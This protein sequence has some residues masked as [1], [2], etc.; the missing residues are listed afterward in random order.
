LLRIIGA[1]DLEPVPQV[2]V[3]VVIREQVGHC[4]R[5]SVGEDG[6]PDGENTAIIV[7]LTYLV[8]PLA[9]GICGESRRGVEYVQVLVEGVAVLGWVGVGVVGFVASAVPGV[10]FVRHLENGQLAIRSYKEVDHEWNER[11]FH[12]GGVAVVGG[13][14]VPSHGQ[15][16]L[17]AGVPVEVA[18]RCDEASVADVVGAVDGGVGGQALDERA[19]VFVPPGVVDR[20][21][22]IVIPVAVEV[23]VDEVALEELVV[24]LGQ[25]FVELEGEAYRVRVGIAV[26][27]GGPIDEIGLRE[28]FGLDQGECGEQQD[29]QERVGV[30]AHL[31][32]G[33]NSNIE[34]R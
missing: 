34:N 19:V 32:S 27:V 2:L 26:G 21:L 25:Y 18:Q 29:K 23:G 4:Q 15:S 20:D 30:R 14:V 22:E 7:Y 11:L 24:E 17:V 1:I 33:Y 28:H 10:G 3:G 5:G 31:N 13:L 9:G 12:I 16:Q 6:A 8:V